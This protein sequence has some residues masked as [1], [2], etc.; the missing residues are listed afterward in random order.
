MRMVYLAIGGAGIGL[1]L[2]LVLALAANDAGAPE[3]LAS[4][5]TVT[6]GPDPAHRVPDGQTP[7]ED[8]PPIKD[9]ADHYRLDGVPAITSQAASAPGEPAFTTDDVLDFLRT[10]PFPYQRKGSEDPV[11]ELIE[12]LT[13]REAGA[14]IGST[15]Q[16][17]GDTLVCLVTLRGDFAV[18]DNP[19]E[20]PLHASETGY[21]VFDATTG[22]LLVEA[23]V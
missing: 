23:V 9:I 20:P 3:T 8:I 14:R 7:N 1:I 10:N 17:P 2:A 13:A 11:V 21:Y 19:S 18:F 16:V 12:F 22:N 5:T 4:E 6:P 15:I